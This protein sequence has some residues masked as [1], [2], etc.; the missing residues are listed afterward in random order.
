MDANFAVKMA[1]ANG[2]SRHIAA[3][4]DLDRKRDEAEVE[5]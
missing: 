4:R 2:P 5:R 1:S 3:P